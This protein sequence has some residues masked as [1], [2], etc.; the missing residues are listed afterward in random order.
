MFGVTQRAYSVP[1]VEPPLADS[2]AL[3]SLLEELNKGRDAFT[4]VKRMR[5]LLKDRVVSG[6]RAQSSLQ[7]AI[8]A[9]GL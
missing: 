6:V 9:A 4:F 2:K 8:E 3:D 5:A 7:E 1:I